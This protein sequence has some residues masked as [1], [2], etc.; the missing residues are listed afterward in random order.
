MQSKIKA[1]LMFY[2]EVFFVFDRSS[3]SFLET[4]STL[5]KSIIGAGILA[6]P[7]GLM[8]AK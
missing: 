3:F 1:T 2:F 7:A 8:T 6:L 4:M 5:T